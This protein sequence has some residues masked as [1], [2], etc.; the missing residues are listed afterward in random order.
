MGQMLPIVQRDGS[1]PLD[2]LDRDWKDQRLRFALDADDAKLSKLLDAIVEARPKLLVRAKDVAA[3]E[4]V[5]RVEKNALVLSPGPKSP[6]KPE[7][8]SQPFRFGPYP[9]DDQLAETLKARVVR[10]LRAECLRRLATPNAG[11]KLPRPKA[12]DEIRFD[13]HM[14]RE[15]DDKQLIPFRW[16]AGRIRLHDGDKIVATITNSSR[17]AI[18]LTMLYIDSAFA[19]DE[20]F[21]I[22]DFGE[23]NR[24]PPGGT[25][26]RV[27]GEITVDTY[28]PESFLFIAAKA[29]AKEPV[30]FGFLAQLGLENARPSRAFNRVEPESHALQLLS[31]EVLPTRRPRE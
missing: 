3:A 19:I 25:T 14:R 8:E 27:T 22:T 21:P 1:I 28:G 16:D 6:H 4:W 5:L 18:D 15:R 13:V 17:F 31:W 12:D 9:I 10:I 26:K 24:I 23:K 2:L 29:M 7:G 20:F 11:E 30:S